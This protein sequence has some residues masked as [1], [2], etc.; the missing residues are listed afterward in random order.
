MPF[1]GVEVP[2]ESTLLKFQRIRASEV[3]AGLLDV[4]PGDALLQIRRLLGFDGIP[5]VLE[6][7]SL[8]AR[9][10]KGLTAAKCKEHGSHIYPLLEIEYGVKMVRADERLTAVVASAEVAKVLG[11][12]AASPLLSVDRIAYT[13]GDRP[14][15]V[16]RGLYRTD[17][18]N[19]TSRR[20]G[21]RRCARRP[22]RSAR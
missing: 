3:V 5:T 20:R 17:P 15:E 12:P 16:R 14:V 6:D 7:I 21:A 2:A 1:D 4:K 8:P 10:F 22:T 9:M 18:H 11:V 19:L 13:Y